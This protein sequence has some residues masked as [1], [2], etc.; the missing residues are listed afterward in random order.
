VPATR[1]VGST[2]GASFRDPATGALA[3]VS[4]GRDGLSW[5]RG[6]AGD[7]GADGDDPQEKR[8]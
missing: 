2:W 7:K 6:R 3:G 5:A 8:L 1:V 4:T